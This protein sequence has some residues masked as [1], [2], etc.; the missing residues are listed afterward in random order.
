V[1]SQEDQRRVRVCDHCL[2]A[3]CWAFIFPC[4]RAVTAGITTR[5]VA[6]L[7]EL[8]REHPSYWDLEEARL[9]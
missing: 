7:R 8:D 6:E 5:T 1:K 2:M 4:D 3:S 9:G